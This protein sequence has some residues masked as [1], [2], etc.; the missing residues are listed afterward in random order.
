MCFGKLSGTAGRTAQSDCTFPFASLRSTRP[1][2][3]GFVMRRRSVMPIHH[4]MRGCDVEWFGLLTDFRLK[5]RMVR[6]DGV[7][8]CL[9]PRLR[10][11]PRSR[12][13]SLTG[14]AWRNG[15]ISY[16]PLRVS[17]VGPLGVSSSDLAFP[18]VCMSLPAAVGNSVPVSKCPW[19]RQPAAVGDSVQ[20]IRCGR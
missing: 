7:A 9:P 14:A 13:R 3:A 8:P 15:E 18:S 1:S 6:A 17:L 11:D 20:D 12:R 4:W 19:M 2:T 16:A 10:T 5:N